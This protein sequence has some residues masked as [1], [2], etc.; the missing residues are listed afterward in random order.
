M[1]LRNPSDALQILALSGDNSEQGR[2]TGPSSAGDDVLRGRMDAAHAQS[3]PTAFD[4]YALV[5]RGILRPGLV[6]ELL[7]KCVVPFAPS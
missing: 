5:Q 2:N 3:M 6:S 7:L 4:D 1:E